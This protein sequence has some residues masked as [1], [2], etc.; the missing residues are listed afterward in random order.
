[1]STYVIGDIHGCAKSLRR[2]LEMISP[3]EGDTLITLGD[4]VDRGPNSRGVI[5]TLLE[6]KKTTN[7]IA[8]KG[9]HELIMEEAAESQIGMEWW[10]QVG[11]RETLQSYG[12]KKPSGIPDEHWEF[13]RGGL[14][15]YKT[16]KFIYVHGGVK[17][18][19]PMKSHV[20]DDLCWLRVHTAKPHFT[21]RTVICGHTPQRDGFP[22]NLGHTICIDTWVFHKK[23]WLTCLNPKTGKYL[24][25]NERGKKRRGSLK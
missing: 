5:K 12:K 10:M 20:I 21:G 18:Q 17:P 11:G 25:T 16:K 19:L 24:Q 8:L 15:Y 1:M 14:P 2:M 4:Y 7:L 22:L 6:V 3:G 9:N 23:G 13:V